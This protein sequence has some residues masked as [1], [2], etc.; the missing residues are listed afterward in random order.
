MTIKECIMLFWDDLSPEFYSL[1]LINKVRIMTNRPQVFDGSILRKM[2][3]LKQEGV[4]DF[5]CISH[6]KSQYRKMPI[7]DLGKFSDLL[8]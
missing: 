7:S 4:I 3:E 6:S 1:T 5:V 2:R 8:K